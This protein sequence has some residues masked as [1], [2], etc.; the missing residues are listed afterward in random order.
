LAASL[1]GASNPGHSSLGYYNPAFKI[2][3]VNPSDSLQQPSIPGR[4]NPQDDWLDNLCVGQR[5][6]A[7]IGN[8]KVTGKISR[9]FK[10]TDNEGVFVEMITKEGKRYKVDGSRISIK[11]SGNTGDNQAR[12]D[13]DRAISSPAFFAENAA[14]KRFVK[15]F[16]EFIETRF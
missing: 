1:F 15:L 14:P 8:R 4:E 3:I 13:Q 5:I 16:E 7:H 9:I 10:N 2:R 12:V 6:V 11:D